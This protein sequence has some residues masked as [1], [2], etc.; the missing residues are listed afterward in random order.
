VIGSNVPRRFRWV[1]AVACLSLPCADGW[2]ASGCEDEAR[3]GV[4]RLGSSGNTEVIATAVVDGDTFVSTID[5]A[6]RRIRLARI[7]AP[8]KRQAY[9]HRAEQALRDLVWK[10]T[11]QIRWARLDRNC[12]PIADVR[13]DGVD[14]SEAMVRKGMAW[15]Y[16]AYSQAPGLK[17]IEQRARSGHVGLWSDPSPTPPWEWRRAHDK[18]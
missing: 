2:A 16:T 6:A 5:G 8:E 10:R 7:D 1:L 9:G 18:L 11:V 4:T 12:R 14:V 13:V 15:Q 17:A 3:R